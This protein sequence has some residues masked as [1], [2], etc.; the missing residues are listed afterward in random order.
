MRTRMAWWLLVGVLT[1]GC[2]DAVGEDPACVGKCDSGAADATSEPVRLK[3]GVLATGSRKL[4]EDHCGFVP[5]PVYQG[6][7]LAEG[8]APLYD[9]V[10]LETALLEMRYIEDSIASDRDR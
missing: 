1:S 6:V 10:G 2:H 3:I 5:R 4:P 9:I 7:A 8:E